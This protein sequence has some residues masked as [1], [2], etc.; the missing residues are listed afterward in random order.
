VGLERGPLSLV[1][2]IEELLGRKSSGSGLESREHG[3]RGPSRR[4]RGTLYPQ[5]LTLT[6]L[7]SNGRSVGIVCSRTQVMEF[8]FFF[9]SVRFLVMLRSFCFRGMKNVLDS[10]TVQFDGCV[11]RALLE[12][13]PMICC[14][15]SAGAL[16]WYFL[17]LSRVMSLDVSATTGQKCVT[18]LQQ[19]AEEMSSRSSPYHLLL[20]T[21]FGRLVPLTAYYNRVVY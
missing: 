10:V 18:L 21:R 16:R 14:S 11:L 8:F 5:M 17:L 4:P 9:C 12:W 6:L 3:R 19:I 15:T 1:S 7:I 13:L 20:R 2:T